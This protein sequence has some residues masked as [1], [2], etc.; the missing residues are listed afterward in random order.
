MSSSSLKI[1]KCSSISPLCLRPSEILPSFGVCYLFNNWTIFKS[2]FLKF[3]EWKCNSI[4]AEYEYKCI[5]FWT[6]KY[7]QNLFG[8]SLKGEGG[9]NII[10]SQVIDSFM[11]TSCFILTNYLGNC[12]CKMYKIT[13]MLFM[14]CLHNFLKNTQNFLG[15][16]VNF[17][18]K[19]DA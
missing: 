11:Y 3:Q 14:T 15:I 18:F 10:Y 5:S 2:I 4:W 9:Q 7:P 12:F 1:S 6:N 17:L 19:Y 16:K 8:S 13:Y